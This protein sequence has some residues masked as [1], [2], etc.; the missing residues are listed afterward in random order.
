MQRVNLL[1]SV[2]LFIGLALQSASSQTMSFEE[3]EPISTLVVPEHIVTHAKYPI[4][5]V[6]SHHWRLTPGYL[7]SVVADMDKL[8]LGVLVNLSGRGFALISNPQKRDLAAEEKF[9]VGGMK[10]IAAVCPGRMV[11]FTNI[12]YVGI[13]EPGWTEETVKQIERDI[14]LGAVGLK[15]YKDLGLTLKYKNGSRVPVDDPKFDPIWAKC[16]ELGVPVLIHSGEPAAFWKPKDRFNE[17]W[18]ELKQKPNRY[19]DPTEY[20]P[21]QQVMQEQVNI[22]AKHPETTFISAHMGWRANDLESLGKLLDAHPNMYTEIGAVLAELGRQPRHARQWFIKYQDRILFGKDL[23]RPNEYRVY[24]RV[25]ETSDEY[26]DYYRKRHA[27][28]KMYGL[29]LPDDVLKKLYYKN[30]LKIIPGI[31]ATRFPD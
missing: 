5:D 19:R 8:N 30:A 18:L 31:D 22:F 29:A 12:S 4:I 9:F 23:W 15:I 17:R 1:S 10:N 24:F 25:L 13:D 3:Y 20:P 28:W 27:F 6:H 16:G 7:D 14:K 2:C 21:W 26:F 11:T